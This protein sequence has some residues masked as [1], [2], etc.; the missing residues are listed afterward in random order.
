MEDG[1]MVLEA[2]KK[3]VEDT[4]PWHFIASQHFGSNR[5]SRSFFNDNSKFDGI[6]YYESFLEINS[7]SHESREIQSRSS[8]LQLEMTHNDFDS[9]LNRFAESAGIDEF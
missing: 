4:I 7:L 8:A 1:W 3:N 9:G 2:Q 6:N 5:H